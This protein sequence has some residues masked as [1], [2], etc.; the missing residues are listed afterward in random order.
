[1]IT[2]NT[3]TQAFGRTFKCSGYGLGALIKDLDHPKAIE[4]GCDIGDT[5]NFL[6]DSNPTLHLTSVDPY[7]E[8][9]DWNGRLM[10]DREDMC[11]RMTDRLKGYFNRFTHI[12]KTS[13][14]AA[15][16]FADALSRSAVVNAPWN[17][18]R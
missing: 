1:M 18:T 17:A 4:I 11:K 6:L 7:M 15:E 10:N 5:A 2:F 9:Q 16:M 8:Y 14:D 3:D 13:D 12:R